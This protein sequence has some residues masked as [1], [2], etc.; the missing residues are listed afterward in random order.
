MSKH[1]YERYFQVEWP[2]GSTV[3]LGTLLDRFGKVVDRKREKTAAGWLHTIEGTGN[4][5][6]PGALRRTPDARN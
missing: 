3:F 4:T 1:F 5:W 2:I 6:T